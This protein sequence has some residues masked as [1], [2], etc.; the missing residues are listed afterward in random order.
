MPVLLGYKTQATV[1]AYSSILLIQSPPFISKFLFVLKENDTNAIEYQILGSL[2]GVNWVVVLATADLAKNASVACASITDP[3]I[4]LD[5]QIR[6]D[7]GD[8]HGS[9]TAYCSGF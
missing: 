7:V 9:V 2:D 5:L 8:S 3:W 6:S 4:W 1:N